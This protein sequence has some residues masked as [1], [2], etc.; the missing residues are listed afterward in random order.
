MIYL[1]HNATTPLHPQVKAAVIGAL[2]ILGNPSSAHQAGREAR[3]IREEAR[4]VTAD[5]LQVLPE[6]V[7]FTSGG[8]EANNMVL[9]GLMEPGDHL[10]T[11]AI[12][13]PSVAETARYLQ[14]RGVRVTFLPV[15]GEGFI[16][17]EDLEGA[18]TEEDQGIK[19]KTL[20]SLIHAN[21]EVG[22]IQDILPIGQ[23]CRKANAYLHIDA[24]QSFGK[25][26][27][28][29]KE[30]PID[31]LSFSGHKIYGPKG[32]G[33]LIRRAHAPL[34]SP[35]IHGGHQ[36]RGRRAG[37]ENLPALAGLTEAIRIRSEV[38]EEEAFRLQQLKTHLCQRI[39]DQLSPVMMNHPDRN[40]LPG[41]ANISFLDIEGEALL[42]QL[43]LRDVAVSTGSACSTGSLEP[44]PV[45]TALGAAAE[46]AHSSLRF[47]LGRETTKE[48]ID[49]AVIA[50]IETVEFLRTMSPLRIIS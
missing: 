42:L 31:Y 46:R 50:L 12:E 18:L 1:D 8:S 44:S 33:G 21:N 3:W 32:I 25:L 24:V 35:L 26:P 49:Q 6:E 40:C 37:T 14:S 30:L 7:F 38:M 17:L 11:S 13:H 10:I 2:D 23:L 22:S 43:D 5:F 27:L 15:T 39:E 48:D 41:T 36:E 28:Q 19:G 34:P 47:S 16:R 45:L 4:Q 20:V 9:K 29:L